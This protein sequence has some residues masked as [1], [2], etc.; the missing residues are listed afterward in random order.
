MFTKIPNWH[1]MD[2]STVSL[3]TLVEE[4]ISTCRLE[5]KSP[6]TIRGYH[7]KLMRF[8]RS[9]NGTLADFLT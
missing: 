6:K 5:G 9:I 7:E 1:E 3:T 2:K 8:V 4:Y